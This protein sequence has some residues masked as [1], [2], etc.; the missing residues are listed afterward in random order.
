LSARIPSRYEYHPADQFADAIRPRL[1]PGIAILDVGSGRRP[2][3]DPAARPAGSRYVGLDISASE[4][5]RA[6]DDA[7]TE[8]VV[9]DVSTALPQLDRRFDL[10]VSWQVLE[11][12]A[13]TERALANMHRYLRPGGALVAV[14]SGRFA[15]YGVVNRL[16]PDR[17]A[18]W[19]LRTFLG[20]DP[21]S[22]Y[23][24]HYDRCDHRGLTELLA[25]WRTAQVTPIYQGGAYLNFA[26]PVRAAYLSYESWAVRSG[27][28]NLATHYLVV[29]ER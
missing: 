8:T 14:L 29:A 25:S 4:L 21:A 28:T 15:V 13:S 3:I 27:R 10:L 20:R 16:V 7:Y 26:K 17:L 5:S 19:S 6:A 2:A 24:A 11:H 18:R 9:A 1:R 23:T 22:V 12:V